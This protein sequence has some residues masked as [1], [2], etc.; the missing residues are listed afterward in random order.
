MRRVPPF[1]TLLQRLC[2]CLCLLLAACQKLSPQQERE[3]RLAASRGDLLVALAWPL[4]G[5]K[6][7]L[8]KGVQLATE[9]VNAGGGA[10]D[11][12]ALRLL[13]KDDG[14]TLA[15]GRMAAQEIA[16]HED[17]VATIGHL[18]TFI[19]IPAARIYERA[20]ILYLSPGSSGNKLTEGG[21]SLTFRTLQ[22]N[23][24]QGRQIC[25]YARSQGLHNIA[26][27]YIKNEYGTDLAN[28]FEQQCREMGVQIADRR[29]Y[30]M[31]GDHYAAVMHDW[32]SLLHF[33]AIFLAGSLPE[34]AQIVR[35]AR[36]AGI[37]VPI[38]GAAGL[39]SLQLIELGGRDVEG[40]VVFS[41]FS[42][43]TPRPEVAAFVKA[44]QARFGTLP[45]S[46]AAQGYDTMMLL[47]RALRDARSAVPARIAESLRQVRGFQ[48]VTGAFD[49]S[50]SGD[51][52]GKVMTPLV[53]R[54]GRFQRLEAPALATS[55]AAGGAAAS[56]AAVP[57]P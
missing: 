47:A 8:L 2:L 41:Q 29:S 10:F 57:P 55:A 3:Q 19:A 31:G 4:G 53:V 5:G 17:V 13:V 40:V 16:N 38:F 35:E 18:N 27:Y 37:R 14:G 6:S 23:S 46:S 56:D 50:A 15:H 45:D 44:Y 20:G 48:G 12:R 32:A 49:V 33:D 26:V 24:D 52:I 1:P 43:Q 39:D 25:D 9:Q 51:V 54:E 21:S 30:R 28:H 7:T 11:G 36:Q 42:H 34:S 22:N